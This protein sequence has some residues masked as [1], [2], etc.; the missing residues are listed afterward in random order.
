MNL[1]EL[2]FKNCLEVFFLNSLHFVDFY[3]Q[4]NR[5]VLLV[6]KN[7]IEHRQVRLF[8]DPKINNSHFIHVFHQSLTNYSWILVFLLFS[9]KL[10]MDRFRGV[11]RYAE[12]LNLLRFF[13][14]RCQRLRKSQG[15]GMAMKAS[16]SGVGYE[17]LRV[18]QWL[19]K[20]QSLGTATKVSGFG[21][22]YESLGV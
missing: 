22:G 11:S 16:E 7:V 14:C 20:P 10:Q 12:R 19:W 15:S 6:H 8:W 3:Y 17:S 13:L 5:K 21:G 18:R 2:F 4:H 1:K 9:E